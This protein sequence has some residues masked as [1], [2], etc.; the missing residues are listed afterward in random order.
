MARY[1]SS[2]MQ[3]ELISKTRR[4]KDMHALQSLGAS[5]VKADLVVIVVALEEAPEEP[6]AVGGVRH[7]HPRARAVRAPPAES[8]VVDGAPWPQHQ[9]PRGVEPNLRRG[10]PAAQ[11]LGHHR[12]VVRQGSGRSQ[13]LNEAVHEKDG[14]AGR[15]RGDSRTQRLERAPAVSAVVSVV[16]V[17]RVYV[18]HPL[19]RVEIRIRAERHALRCSESVGIG[20]HQQ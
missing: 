6:S 12:H 16:P 3:D 11:P 13:L 8:D 1:H 2:G 5:L 18:E 20:K 10:L 7:L 4:K 15:R 14:P 17:R 9:L 19:G